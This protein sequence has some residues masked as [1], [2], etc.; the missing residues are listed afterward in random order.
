MENEETYKANVYCRN[1]DFRKEI[2]IPKGQVIEKTACPNCG[3]SE[4]LKD[5]NE[6]AETQ[7][8]Y[9]FGSNR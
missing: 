3:N 1:C 2:E 7:N 8:Y 4:L 9:D 6:K 5:H